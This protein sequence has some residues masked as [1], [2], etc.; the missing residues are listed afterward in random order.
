MRISD[1]S[2]DVCSSDLQAPVERIVR[3]RAALPEVRLS[4][5]NDGMRRL[6][7]FAKPLG[8]IRVAVVH[9]CDAASL[10]GAVDACRAG[11]IE[12]VLIGPRAR[13]LAVAAEAGLAIDGMAMERSEESGVGEEW[14]RTCRDR[15]SRDH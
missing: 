8:T 1:W 10:G 15:G 2:S 14:V 4:A 3:P 12:P 6:L 5:G 11:L 9:P 7:D 13:L